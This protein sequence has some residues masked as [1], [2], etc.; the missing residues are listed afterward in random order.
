MRVSVAMT[1]YNGQ[2]YLNEQL[3]SIKDQT[4]NVDEVIIL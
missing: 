3:D 2:A 4:K 1:I